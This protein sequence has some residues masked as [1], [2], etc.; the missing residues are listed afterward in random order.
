MT[1]RTLCR[2]DRWSASGSAS[3][4][5]G[6]SVVGSV[7]ASSRH[8]PSTRLVA[9]LAVVMVP[10]ALAGCAAGQRAQTANEFSVVDGASANIGS[11]GVRNAGVASPTGPAGYVKGASAA[12]SMTVINNGNSS[13]TLVSVTT[14]NAARATIT[15]PT[16]TAAASTVAGATTTGIS[17]PANGAVAVG[18]GTGAAKITLTGLTLALIPG[19]LVPVTLNFRAA[20]QVTVQLP[21]KLVPGQTGGQT[22]DVAPP[23]NA[24]A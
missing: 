18:A 14:P 15:A 9:A 2:S 23:T 19:Q 3:G 1:V 11:M 16:A 24:G 5:A 21:V 12:L 10:G 8:R 20:G 6:R 4:A 22:V 13:D 17:V 7:R